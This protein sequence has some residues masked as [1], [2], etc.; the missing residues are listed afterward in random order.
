MYKFFLFTSIILA[1]VLTD[2]R[3]VSGNGLWLIHNNDTNDSGVLTTPAG[4]PMCQTFGL[5]GTGEICVF[6]TKSTAVGAN[7]TSFA[8]VTSDTALDALAAWGTGAPYESRGKIKRDIEWSS[9]C[10][11]GGDA[12]SQHHDYPTDNRLR[13]GHTGD[14]A[15][16]GYLDARNFYPNSGTAQ[17]YGFAQLDGSSISN[18][19]VEAIA[20]FTLTQGDSVGIG[21]EVDGSGSAKGSAGF[22]SAGADRAVVT[23]TDTDNVG[24]LEAVEDGDRVQILGTTRAK[25]N[26]Q[27]SAYQ[28]RITASTSVSDWEMYFHKGGTHNSGCSCANNP[29][30]H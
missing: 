28:A 23:A 19:N 4:W 18:L 14:C 22:T 5:F 30:S 7:R 26:V 2:I 11:P 1:S 13:W 16:S 20:N 29:H 6:K 27:N 17:V 25:A 3:N 10:C 24:D 9:A 12:D 15:L 8:K 21:G